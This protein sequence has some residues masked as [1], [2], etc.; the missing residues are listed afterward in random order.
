MEIV[1]LSPENVEYR[2]SVA[3]LLREAFPHSYGDGAEAE[4]NSCL[5]EGRIALIAVQDGQ[6]AGFVG[7]IPQYGCTGWE[8]HP[9]VVRKQ[10]QL[11]GIGSRLVSA[12]EAEVA[13]QGG[14]TI[15]LG[16]DDEFGQTS[17]SG[18]DL[19]ENLWGQIA[20]ISNPGRHPYEFYVK[21]GYAIVGAIPDANGRGKPD[22]L[23][24]KRVS[25]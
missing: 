7:A 17:L 6:V 24:A 23:M 2:A 9:L 10:A 15:Y 8:L 12:L 5:E 11:S 13:R 18:A 21:N 14:L 16:T 4:V 25:R 22:I 20:N 19:Y 3:E 1:L